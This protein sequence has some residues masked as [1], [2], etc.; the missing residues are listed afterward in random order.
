MRIADFQFPVFKPYNSPTLEIYVS[1]CTRN[2][3]NCC[4]P[5]LQDYSYGSPLDLDEL[6]CRLIER[7]GLFKTLSVVGGDLLCQDLEDALKLALMLRNTLPTHELWLFTGEEDINKI[8][9]WCFEIF[10]VIKYGLYDVNLKQE[11]FPASSN[12]HV[13]RKHANNNIKELE[14]FV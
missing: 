7:K 2:C 5:E 11:G 6:R 10:D 13:W 1:G 12:Q 3:V 14:R 8:P 9:K 4:N